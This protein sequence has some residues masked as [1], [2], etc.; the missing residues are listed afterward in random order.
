MLKIYT[1]ENCTKQVSTII[2]E[3]NI[4]GNT[5]TEFNCEEKPE[6][7]RVFSSDYFYGKLLT[8][9][10]EWNY[11]EGKIS[12]S[13]FD[14]S[15]IVLIVAY[16]A[17]EKILSEQYLLT[18]GSIP[19]I[20]QPLWM[21]ANKESD[22]HFEVNVNAH[23]ILPDHGADVSWY[24]LSLD[25]NG[26]PSGYLPTGVKL[27]LGDF[28]VGVPTPSDVVKKFW[29]KCNHQSEAMRNNYRDITL[30]I[31]SIAGSNN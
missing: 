6:E 26:T 5:V 30:K 4:S 3:Y 20:E 23:D 7:I 24:Q 2:G 11:S 16:S 15:D 13:D 12:I 8:E 31:N 19:N 9:G 18:D 21:K 27:E 14:L 17:G 1:D 29:I 22:N 28:I 10:A 25:S